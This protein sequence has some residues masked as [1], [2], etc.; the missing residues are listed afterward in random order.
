[1]EIK[2][3]N[4]LL[5]LS[6]EVLHILDKYIQRKLS[7]PESGG[8]ILGKVT[9][10]TIQIQRLSTPTELDKCSR[11]NFERHRL[12]AQIVIN[13]EHANSY[14]Q[15]AY[16]GE[17]HTHPEDYPSPSSTDIKMIKQQF[18]QNKIHTDFLILLI[19]GRKSLFAAL[20]NKD[21]IVRASQIFYRP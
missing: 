13:Y 1:M 21:G 5:T 10:D 4:Y 7:D 16:L 3:D 8:I 9:S 15:V 6:A 19:Q 20:I 18:A 17:W 14:G 12:S 2:I 11:M